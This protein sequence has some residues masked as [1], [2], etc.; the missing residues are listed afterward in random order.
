M[1][2]SILIFQA[3]I[4]SNQDSSMSTK[5]V[6]NTDNYRFT[7]MLQLG[8]PQTYAAVAVTRKFVQS[9]SHVKGVAR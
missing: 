2:N 4:L 3:I 8:L 7:L 6:H 1:P 5:L 9:D